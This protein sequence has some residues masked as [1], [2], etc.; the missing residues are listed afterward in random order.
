LSADY[1]RPVDLKL[2]RAKTQANEL[3]DQIEKWRLQ[4]PIKMKSELLEERFGYQI[5]VTDFEESTKLEEWGILIGEFMH[6]LRSSLDNLAFALA[7]LKEDP[8]SHPNQISFPIFQEEVEFVKKSK[9]KI[10]QQLSANAADMIEKIQPFQRLNP[11]ID[12]EPH[13]DPLVLLQWFNN[14][15]KH[16]IPTVLLMSPTGE[17]QKSVTVE[18]YSA[19]DAALNV[20]PQVE[21]FGYPIKTGAILMKHK[22]NKPISK[23]NGEFSLGAN[24]SVQGLNGIESVEPLVRQLH[25]YTALIVDQFRVYFQ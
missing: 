17:I 4:N 11:N 10:S 24:V 25:Y 2:A 14:I 20:P 6:N 13:T 8:P 3:C 23:V 1:I 21:F 5:I 18:F 19:E 12:G 22:T 16:R 7:R 9:S 15:D